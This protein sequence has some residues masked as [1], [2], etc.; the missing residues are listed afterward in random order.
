[1][2]RLKSIV[3]VIFKPFF[4]DGGNS[5]GRGRNIADIFLKVLAKICEFHLQCNIICCNELYKH[6]IFHIGY[7]DL[8]MLT[9]STFFVNLF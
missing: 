9:F 3:Y 5:S 6:Q 4:W 1:M 2:E 7:T 8:S